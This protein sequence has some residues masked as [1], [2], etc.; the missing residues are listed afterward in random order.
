MTAETF[1]RTRY[2]RQIVWF[3]LLAACGVAAVGLL[4]LFG[5]L[6]DI[7]S[8]Q[9][10][11]P[12]FVKM[13]PNAALGFVLM[14]IAV[15]L[16]H[17][18]G[19]RGTRRLVQFAT[20]A[21]AFIGA[22]TLFEYIFGW[23]IGFDDLLFRDA[24]NLGRSL[25]PGRMSPATALNFLLLGSALLLLETQRPAARIIADSLTTLAGLIGCL[26]LLGYLFESPALYRLS[27]F[28]G[29]AVHTAMLFVFLAGALLAAPPIRG[30]ASLL[31]GDDIGAAL[32][33]RLLPMAV[34]V[35]PL[36]GFIRL[37][38]QQEGLYGTE[39]GI[40]LFA[41]SNIVIFV[42]V[43]LRAGIAM[44]TSDLKRRVLESGL[45]ASDERFRLLAA[46]ALDYAIVTLDP[47]GCVVSW[48]LGAER[49]KGYQESEILGRHFS[50]FYTA[51]DVAAHKPEI[52]LSL[53][54]K[55]GTHEEEGW[56]V[57]K[58]GSRYWASGSI[59]TLRDDRG[60]LK[61]FGKITRDITE[62]RRAEEE[63]RERDQRLRNITDNLTEGLV[64]ASLEG[65]LLHWNNAA[66]AMFGFSS[67]EE[68]LRM[69]P[70]FIDT[71]ELKT[72]DG[73]VLRL[74]EW[75]L[76]LVIAGEH[77]RNLELCIR[78]FGID[79]Q[80]TLSF[81]GAIV[82]D[83]G[84]KGVAFLSFADITERK[85][86]DEE[87][88]ASEQR[89]RFLADTLP[90]IIWTAK[91][92]GNLDYY[93]QRWF[94]YTG[95]TFEQTKD[96]GWQ[97]VVHPD[98]LEN[99]VD[100][101]TRA[102][103]TGCDYEVEYRFKRASDGLYRWHLGRAFPLRDGCGEILQWIGTCTDI[104]GKKQAEEKLRLAHA[105]LESRVR[106]RTAELAIAKERAEASDRQKSLFLA[107][108][109]HELRTPLNAIIGFTQLIHDDAVTPE[110]P[111]YKEFLG[112]VLT[113]GKHL[114]QL[115]NDVLDLSAVDAGKLTFSPEVV[116]LCGLIKE[117]LGILRTSA[118]SK[119]LRLESYVDPALSPVTLDPAR[120]KQVLY[121]YVSN[122][123]KFTPEGGRVQIRAL[124]EPSDGA[125][126]LEVEDTGI[127][128]AAEDIGRLFSEFQQLD[129]GAAKQHSGTG[130]GLALTKRLVEA[131]GGTVGVKSTPGKGSLF[132]AIFPRHVKLGNHLPESQSFR[133][134]TAN[135]PTVFVIEDNARDQAILVK[136]LTD[137]GYGVDTATNGAQAFTHC[138]DQIYDAIT[139]DILLPDMSGVDTLSGIRAAEDNR[140][141][142]VIVVTVVT[143]PKVVA[144]AEVHDLL[145]KPVDG[146]KLLASLKR[147]GVPP[148]RSGAVLLVD[149][150]AASLKLMSV[151]LAQLGYRAAC[152]SNGNDGLRIAQQTQPV[153]VVVDLLM[154]EMN[155]FEFI[156]RFRQL[157]RCR[158]VPVIVWTVKDL[159]AEEHSRI[160][161]SAQAVVNKGS[162]GSGAVVE[163]LQAFLPIGAAPSVCQE[164]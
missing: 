72:L 142:P 108:M 30:V 87:L 140:T 103:Q 12:N 51:E 59:T 32:V 35:P 8:L 145:S 28:N 146:A 90:Q 104:E 136:T 132:F 6:L 43:I 149:D 137:A 70:A 9:S 129:E 91:P 156:S 94:D 151:A 68:W 69:L 42:T 121:N 82:R 75:P 7:Q 150:D 36:V 45:H 74:E 33:R 113:G 16:L 99:C 123:L 84:G 133:G 11:V 76:A 114:L 63:Q 54:L 4:V 107:N 100:R 147:A 163:E 138:R 22:L 139:P 89:Y 29:M 148:E 67:E 41:T 158:R 154:P 62:R 57:R 15:A 23:N 34:I 102:Y 117:V 122:A 37:I 58:D 10:V 73:R 125:L 66:R 124:A 131:Q 64:I 106:E 65:E 120:L 85:R 48:N 119:H 153:A 86:V 164:G 80:L 50:C 155:G 61:G 3:S 17:M 56:R 97:P 162:G 134:H 52:N 27:G 160:L 152:A 60:R 47:K 111:Q 96:W 83:G 26:A 118:A 53:A 92:D 77:V 20:V 31:G 130:L 112:D 5:W 144:G 78:R 109:S 25:T 71:F 18:P 95:L 101:W 127:G 143:D 135:A 116:D 159:T 115:I 110:M 40:A 24:T 157:P 161:A 39:F 79:R 1:S 88:R 49:I 14:G 93:N 19:S 128:I 46:G 44:R 13:R 2:Q 21:A 55:E 81:S 126:R 105:G 98:D 141:T 38:G